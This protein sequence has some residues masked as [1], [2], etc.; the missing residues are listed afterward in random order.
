MRFSM[1]TFFKTEPRQQSIEDKILAMSD[2]AV[3]VTVPQ[4]L[5]ETGLFTEHEIERAVDWLVAYR[6]HHHLDVIE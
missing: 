3:H 6:E 4:Q 1:L 2:H 5:R